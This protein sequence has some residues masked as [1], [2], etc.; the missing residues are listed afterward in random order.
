MK[1]LSIVV[2]EDDAS[3]RGILCDW[4]TQEGHRVTSASGG[5]EASRVIDG[6]DI[7][8]VVTDVIMPEGNGLELIGRLK[9]SH[10]G[11]RVLAISGG[12]SETT[13][14]LCLLRAHN[15]GAHALLLK[16][17]KPDQLREAMASLFAAEESAAMASKPSS[18]KPGRAR[19]ARQPAAPE[20]ISRSRELP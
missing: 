10:P 6:R 20:R 17:F 3:T 12:G 4:L 9:K 5:H 16:P 2:V 15:A 8:L 13:S 18:P 7:D 1:P 19:T 11:V 14:A